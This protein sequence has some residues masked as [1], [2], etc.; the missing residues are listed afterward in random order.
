MKTFQTKPT[1]GVAQV[2]AVEP[3]IMGLR[4]LLTTLLLLL[5]LVSC[6]DDDTS[7][8]EVRDPSLP[9]QLDAFMPDSGGIR[10]KFIVK[11]FNFGSDIS[12]IQVLFSSDER[13][14]TVLG[15]NNNTIYCQV[16]KQS[17]GDN[18]V[19][20]VVEEDT[21]VFDRTFRYHVEQNVSTISGVVGDNTLV[22]GTLSEARFNYLYGVAA[23]TG[24]DI[25]VAEMYAGNLRYVAVDDNK[26]STLQ[27]NFY[28]GTPAV[29]AN[30]QQVYFVGKS[31]PHKIYLLDY[32]NLWEPEL[33]VSSIAGFNGDIWSAAFDATE[34]WLYF[35]DSTGK[36]GRLEMKNPSNVEVL[37]EDLPRGNGS[38]NNLAYS[39]WHDCFFYTV[40]STQAVYRL[41]KD[42]ETVEL[43]MGGNGQGT[44]TGHRLETA[45]LYYP[46]G[47]T[48]DADGNIYVVNIDGHTILKCDRKSD[49]VSLL[50]GKPLTGGHKD[51]EPLEALFS[52]PYGISIDEDGNFI[53]C[54]C[55]GSGVVRKLA[56]E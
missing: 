55:W 2:R 16:P 24:G 37:S 27:T 47:L 34:A 5:I 28:T 15:V 41:S 23:V 49:F 26:V 20:V 56:I 25:I 33:F 29:S 10:T 1:E 52:L 7:P 3:V 19:T 22:D 46:G 51:G 4:L 30:R 11:G 13:A 54:E 9:V 40:Y 17:D 48:V 39:A 14:A 6:H 35:F 18:S 31:S 12:K 38:H 44:A 8:G 45:Q 50:A 42:G 53:I 43:W 36:F 32:N 21:V